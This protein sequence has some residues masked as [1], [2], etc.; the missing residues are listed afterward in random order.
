[1]DSHIQLRKVDA[2]EVAPLIAAMTKNGHKLT[3][4]NLNERRVKPSLVENLLFKD[5][6]KE[7]SYTVCFTKS[8][9]VNDFV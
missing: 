9:D 6:Q 7:T 3:G 1:M 8:G 2:A 4:C 5:G